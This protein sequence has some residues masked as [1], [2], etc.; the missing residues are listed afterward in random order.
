MSKEMKHDKL[1]VQN[2]KVASAQNMSEK[3]GWIQR[4]LDKGQVNLEQKQ[5]MEQTDLPAT[6]P[7][8]RSQG[9]QDPTRPGP[10]VA[11]IGIQHAL[12]RR[13]RGP[14]RP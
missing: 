3:K 6:S 1:E 13:G 8:Q 10:R 11:E 5:P 14:T 2:C 9:G 4:A 7:A 12:G